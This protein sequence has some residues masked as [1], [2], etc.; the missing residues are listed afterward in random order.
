MIRT[1]PKGEA[2]ATFFLRS[3]SW[4]ARARSPR[5][6]CRVGHLALEIIWPLMTVATEA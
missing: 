4:S 2:L 1:Y 6:D 3:R 5:G